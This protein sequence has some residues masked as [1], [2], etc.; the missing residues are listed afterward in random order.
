MRLS[1]SGDNEDVIKGDGTLE[2]SKDLGLTDDND[3][4]LIIVAWKL[5]VAHEKAWEFTRREWVDG[6]A[7]QG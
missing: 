5:N 1:S 4:S 6:W 2:F 7:Q 3:P